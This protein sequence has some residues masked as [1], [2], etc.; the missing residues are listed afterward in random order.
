VNHHLLVPSGAYG[1]GEY[2]NQDTNEILGSS[3]LLA[4]F[5]FLMSFLTIEPVNSNNQSMR[6]NPTKGSWCKRTTSDAGQAAHPF[7]RPSVVSGINVD[8][9]F[10]LQNMVCRGYNG[11]G[12]NCWWWWWWWWQQRNR[13]RPGR[14]GPPPAS[15]RDH[16]TAKAH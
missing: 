9:L 1:L 16:K 15:A 12:R 13:P 3:F 14:P 10:N 8:T 5:L 2:L 7:G 4:V 6:K 11:H